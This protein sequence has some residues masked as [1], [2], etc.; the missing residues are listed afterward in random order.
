MVLMDKLDISKALEACEFFKDLKPEQIA[1]II[2]ICKILRVDAGDFVYRQGGAGED[3][4]IVAEGQVLLERA[5]SVGARQG[6]VAVAL[7]GKGKVFGG[8]STLLKEAH[9]L[10]LSAVC[11]KPCV[12]VA[13]EGA[14]LRRL[15]TG[16]ILLGFAILERLCFLLRERLQLALGAIE[17]L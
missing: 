8:W 11:R 17:T 10:M 2:P 4:F 6:S 7:L 14:Q 15:M 13:L 5:V 1:A 16:D 12:L 3:L 9:V